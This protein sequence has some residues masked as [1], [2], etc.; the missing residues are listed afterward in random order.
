MIIVVVVVG[1]EQHNIKLTLS[2]T[3]VQLIIDGTLL[4]N[5][6]FSISPTQHTVIHRFVERLW[7]LI[8]SFVSFNIYIE[9]ERERQGTV[10]FHL[11]GT[12]VMPPSHRCVE[13]IQFSH[14]RSTKSTLMASAKVLL[15]RR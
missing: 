6:Q 1:I 8:F 2:E 11:V 9:R 12:G 10:V 3:K 15:W 7:D 13:L 5:T 14:V 4:C